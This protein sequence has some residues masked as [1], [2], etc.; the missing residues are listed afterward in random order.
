MMM[1]DFEPIYTVLII[2]SI[3]NINRDVD[4]ELVTQNFPVSVYLEG[5]QPP[6][7]ILLLTSILNSLTS[8]Q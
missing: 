6:I 2:R 1:Y 4:V 3:K 5:S 7:E 8:S